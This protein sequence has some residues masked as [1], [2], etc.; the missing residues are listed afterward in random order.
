MLPYRLDYIFIQVEQVWITG[1][2][3][4]LN[5]LPFGIVVERYLMNNY[6]VVNFLKDEP[7]YVP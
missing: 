7:E 5:V 6:L 2:S 1:T 3:I 4:R